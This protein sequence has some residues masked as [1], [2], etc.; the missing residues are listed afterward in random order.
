MPDIENKVLA[1]NGIGR[2]NCMERK[3]GSVNGFTRESFY[4]RRKCPGNLN[5]NTKQ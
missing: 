5:I 3:A 1:F 4:R 2:F